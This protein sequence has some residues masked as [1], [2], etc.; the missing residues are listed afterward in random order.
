MAIALH[1]LK[2]GMASNKILKLRLI[3]ANLIFLSDTIEITP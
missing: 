2:N 1:V 3:S